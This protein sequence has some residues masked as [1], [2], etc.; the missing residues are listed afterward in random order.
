[1]RRYSQSRLPARRRGRPFVALAAWLGVTVVVALALAHLAGAG[2]SVATGQAAAPPQNTSPPSIT[3]AA[4]ESQMLQA[5]PGKWRHV[6][7]IKYA[8][9]WQRCGPTSPSSC[10]SI[11]DATDAI[12]ALRHDDVGNTLRVVVTATNPVG[13]TSALSGRTA[14]VAAA[15]VGAPVNAVRP[16]ITGKLLKRNT[17]VAQPGTWTGKQ[18][19]RTRY[20]WRRCTDTGGSCRAIGKTGQTYVLSQADVS[21]TL[22]VLVTEENPVA[23][24]ASLSLPTDTVGPVPIPPATA[25]KSTSAPTIAGSARQGQTLTASSGSWSGTKPIAFSFA[26]MRCHTKGRNCATVREANQ[27]TYTPGSADVQHT[28]RVLVTAKNTAGSSS[29]V[30]DPTGVVSA[31]TVATKP[32]N[33]GEPRISG[34]TQVGHVLQTTSGTWTGTEPIS[35]AYQWR[36]CNGSGRADA[37]DCAVISNANGPT[38][39]VRDADAGFHLRVRVTATNRAGSSTVA[40][41]PTGA[42]S[43]GA[44]TNTAPPT[45]SGTAS[46]GNTLSVNHGQWTGKQPITYSYRWL[47]CEAQTG[48]NCSEISGATNTTYAVTGADVGRSLRVRVTARNDGGSQSAI[49][50]Q[51]NV[52]GG[53]PPPPP[54]NS[55]SVNDVPKTARLIVSEVRFSPNP[56]TSRSAPITV[57]IRVKDTRGFVIRGALVFIRSTPRVTSGAD[58]QATGPDG[59][60]TYQLVPNVNFPQP[61]NGFNVQFFVKAYRAGDPALAGVAA[62]RLVQA[63]LAG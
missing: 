59:W 36:R 62:Y 26:W 52:V 46:P 16:S 11:V 13:N 27:Q 41:N 30:S 20:S 4:V 28:L 23:T 44:P 21:H 54:A 60:V 50:A 7:L 10:T 6:K 61:R 57:R 8:Y 58:R 55:I 39:T 14:V 43:F 37:S 40:S 48:T 47:R 25:P 63:P 1:M 12:Y 49:S 56:V 3:G 31:P 18:P 33:K 22:R 24:G 5:N 32:S 53:S 34:V 38:Y 17:L 42:I 15:P 9:Q 51:R 2:G 45:I 35:Y 19:A 29:R